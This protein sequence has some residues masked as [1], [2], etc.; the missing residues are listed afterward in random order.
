MSTVTPFFPTLTTPGA[1]TNT[2]KIFSTVD[3]GSTNNGALQRA[4]I[5][6]MIV[7]MAHSD[8][9]TLNEYKSQD[10]GVTWDLVSTEVVTAGATTTFREYDISAYQDWKLE[11]VNGNV[12]QNPWRIDIAGDTEPF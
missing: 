4:G 9:G 7:D 6:R 1:D 11:W 2:Y 3:V 12:A 10:R 8:D 5:R